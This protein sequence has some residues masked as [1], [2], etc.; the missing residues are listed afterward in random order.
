[1]LIS[2]YVALILLTLTGLVF[3]P[4]LLVAIPLD[5]MYGRMLYR[6]HKA[7]VAKR[8]ERD[9]FHRWYTEKSRY[10]S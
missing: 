9:A 5:I 3:W 6:H 1:M 4:L 7:L 2:P 8:R 10:V